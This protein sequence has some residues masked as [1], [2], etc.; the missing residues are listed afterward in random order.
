[1]VRF[2]LVVFEM[3]LTL[4]RCCHCLDTPRRRT[5]RR[6]EGYRYVEEGLCSSESPTLSFNIPSQH[7]ADHWSRPQPVTLPLL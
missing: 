6:A 1:M 3:N 5:I 2:L 4:R 7:P